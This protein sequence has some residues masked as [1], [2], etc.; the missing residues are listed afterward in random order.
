MDGV[1]DVDGN[2]LYL[3]GI[4]VV[5]IHSAYAIY[6]IIYLICMRFHAVDGTTVKLKRDGKKIIYIYILRCCIM[7]CGIKKKK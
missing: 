1:G 4:C 2:V 3:T 6:L 7:P 5:I